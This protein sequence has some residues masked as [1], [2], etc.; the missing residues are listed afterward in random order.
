MI[1][2][3]AAFMNGEIKVFRTLPH[4]T[5]TFPVLYTEFL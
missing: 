5:K 1:E 2:R 3:S 4:L